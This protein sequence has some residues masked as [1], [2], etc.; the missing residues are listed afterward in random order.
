MSTVA[1]RHLRGIIQITNHSIAPFI[2]TINISKRKFSSSHPY[3]SNHQQSRPILPLKGIRILD[4]TRVLAGPFG[5]QLL[6]DLGAE[7]IKIEHP[8]YGDITRQWGYDTM[9]TDRIQ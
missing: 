1:V 9:Y 3:H 7:L 4:L 2:I 6:G 8:S 5:T